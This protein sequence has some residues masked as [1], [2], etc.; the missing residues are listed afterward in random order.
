MKIAILEDYQDAVR[1]LPCF[2][3]L[4]GHEVDVFTEPMD[5]D[6]MAQ[7]LAEHEAVVL[8]RE[9]T[10]ITAELLDRLPRLRLISQTG[11][12]SGNV[13]M[14]AAKQQGVA[15]LEGGAIPRHRRS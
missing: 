14:A 7:C 9:R 2:S 13:D 3:L 15:V 6:A 8:I 1:H 5:N 10:H 11:K 12:V 4:Q